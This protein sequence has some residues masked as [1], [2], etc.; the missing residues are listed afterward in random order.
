MVTDIIDHEWAQSIYFY[1]PNGIA[2]EYCCL[3]RDVGNEDDVTMQVRA[4]RISQKMRARWERLREASFN[5]TMAA[6]AD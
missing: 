4:E 5:A 6:S 3:A 1:D 2:L